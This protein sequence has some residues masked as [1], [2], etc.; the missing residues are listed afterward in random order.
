MSFNILLGKPYKGFVLFDSS[1]TRYR[2]EKY[3]QICC[4]KGGKKET[5]VRT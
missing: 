5:M 3:A 1:R 2:R 4:K